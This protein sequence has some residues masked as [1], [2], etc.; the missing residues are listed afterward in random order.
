[1]VNTCRSA[2]SS[3][4]RT[5]TH[6]FGED[7]LVCKFMQS[8]HLKIPPTPK[9][10]NM[11]DIHQVLEP[12]RKWYPNDKLS[13][14]LLTIKLAFLMS[15]TNMQILHIFP[16]LSTKSM[17]K[18][19]YKATFIPTTHP[20]V[21]KRSR[22]VHPISVINYTPEPS[23]NPLQLLDEYITSTTEIRTTD[24][25]FVSLQKPHKNI[26]RDTISRWIKEVLK[27][28]GID[29]NA[30]TAYSTKHAAA[31]KA[32]KQGVS[33]N[34]ILH[35]AGWENEQTFQRFYNID[36][37]DESQVVQAILS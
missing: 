32:N 23:L 1:M 34:D 27:S 36:F 17:I 18:T 19:K 21:S 20:K 25:L 12:L 29:T 9:Y 13:L 33:I 22:K 2:L 7:P 4:I 5:Q 8:I 28:V 31:T 10:S 14:K 35:M 3:F 6:K 37:L 24:Y 26:T 16:S 30:F 11:W 15:I